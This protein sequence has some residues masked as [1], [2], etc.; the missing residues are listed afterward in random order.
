MLAEITI[1]LLYTS[2]RLQI[3][4]YQRATAAQ[5][6][7]LPHSGGHK[8]FKLIHHL[9]DTAVLFVQLF[10]RDKRTAVAHVALDLRRQ[11]ASQMAA[12]SYHA[13]L[14]LRCTELS[15]PNSNGNIRA[16]RIAKA[17][18]ETVPV[19]GT[20]ERHTQV[21]LLYTS[22]RCRCPLCS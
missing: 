9:R 22:S 12:A 21:C 7:S 1:C 11:Y 8:L 15:I 6:P 20:D 10:R 5:F 3:A 17:S 14:R 19:D 18:A 4:Q 2:T 16:G 13:E